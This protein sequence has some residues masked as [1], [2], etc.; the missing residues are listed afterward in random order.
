MDLDPTLRN[1]ILEGKVILFLGS[2][3]SLG[4]CKAGGESIP[5]TEELRD[6]LASRFLDDSWK[7][8]SLSEVAE[9]SISQSD[10]V[11]VQSYI[12][13]VFLGFLPTDFHK[14]IP[15]FRWA[16][17]YTTNYDL[18]IENS[19]QSID[20]AKQELVPIH[21]D[22]D[23]MDSLIKDPTKQLAY[24]KLHGCINR[25]S[26]QDLP[27][28]LTTDQY[29][30]HKDG[31]ASL[32]KRIIEQGTG[33]PILFIGHSLSDTD[34]REV[35]HEISNITSSRPRYWAV[36]YDFREQQR[37]F[38]ESKRITLIKGTFE[39]FINELDKSTSNFEVDFNR[40]KTV[41]PIESKFT[42]NDH[43][44][45]EEALRTLDNPLE[46]IHYNML[47]EEN[48]KPELF[49]H[50]YSHGW[51][52]IQQELDVRR[53]LCDEILSESILAEESERTTKVE[54][55]N[56]S[57][58]AGSGKSVILKRLAFDSSVDYDRICLF[59]D[60][61]EKLDTR[62]ILEIAEK[63]DERVYLFI[64]KA[65]S[66]VNDLLFLIEKFKKSN[67]L[68]TCFIAERTNIWNTECIPLHRYIT[69]TY[70]VRNLSLREIND[71]LDKL[72][73]HKCLGVLTNIDRKQQVS[74]FTNRLDRQLLVALHEA[75]M[76]KSFEEIIQDEFDNIADRKAQL[77][78]RTV[79]TMN[80]FGVPVRAGIIHRIHS[81]TFQDFKEVFFEPL[82]NV[83]HVKEDKY[84]DVS[85][86]ARHPSIAE[87][88]FSHALS[89]DDERLNS[90]ISLIQSLDIGYS[91]DRTAFRELI[92]FKHLN[93]VFQSPE[94][95]EKIYGISAKVCGDDDYYYQ[96]FAIFYMRSKK[97][98]FSLAEKYLYLAKEFGS[99]NSSIIHTWAELELLKATK[100]TGLERERLYNK[101]SRLAQEASTSSTDTS[102]GYSTLC[103]ISISRLEDV[104][105]TEDEELISDAAD[106]AQSQLKY[107]LDCHPDADVILELEAKLATLLKDNER[108]Q[109]ALEK[110]FAINTT[111]SYLA[112]ALGNIYESKGDIQ[113]AIDTYNKVLSDNHNEKLAHAKLAKIYSTSSQFIDKD[114]AE[115]HWQRSFTDGDSNTI[116]K[117]WYSRQL[118]LNNKYD[119]YRNQIEKMRSIRL[120][121]K[122]KNA[123]RGVLYDGDNL[124]HLVGRVKKAEASYLLIETPGYKGI[125]FMHISNCPDHKWEDFSAGSEICY[126]LG[127]TVSGTAAFIS[128]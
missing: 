125:H 4:A 51:N 1:F 118:Y 105:N 46:Y 124:V 20:N 22:S 66:H 120:P 107:A 100:S 84:G 3:A 99:H 36:M 60:S 116:N 12:R 45:T 68:I 90:Y 61:S 126:N 16:G 39:E 128:D 44:L 117:V 34:I 114:K 2:G 81:V 122:T 89:T 67:L 33:K 65:S 8:N 24:T 18:L 25:I 74:E 77:I 92:K 58:S 54:V 95:I 69:N 121:P 113:K 64:D 7:N 103:K 49:Y 35:M 32:F 31:R 76:A 111:N 93:S 102:Y 106:N 23:R 11:T 26:E 82:E 19:Y 79:C 6:I 104:L 62:T 78:Y 83:L 38:W 63:V 86:E 37:S 50:G 127:F 9:I 115:Y 52:P 15:N 91:S 96:Q 30:T 56:I 97:Q 29:V 14:K 112:S 41:H 48:C 42:S 21:R 119:E 72:E 27:L 55:F 88:V 13:D 10:P 43:N 101:A 28:I 53:K 75:T 5:S 109:K 47:T 59:W 108:A 94:D 71:L 87:M 80:Q 73:C 40:R 57:G 123:I 98:R 70:D 85:Y 110:A 17:I